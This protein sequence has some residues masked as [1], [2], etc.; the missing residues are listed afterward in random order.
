MQESSIT[1]AA[2]RLSMTQPSVSNAVSRTPSLERRL[3]NAS[4]LERSFI[5]ETR[6]RDSPNPLCRRVVENN[7]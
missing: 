3:S 5:R 4:R 2:E 6:K 1:V 7:W